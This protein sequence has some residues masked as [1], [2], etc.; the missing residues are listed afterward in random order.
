MVTEISPSTTD[1]QARANPLGY[2]FST[3]AQAAP[4]TDLA[5]GDLDGTTDRSDPAPRTAARFPHPPER[6][7][8]AQQRARRDADRLFCDVK[9]DRVLSHAR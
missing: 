4:P 9:G 1:W 6:A 3:Q 2:I 8:L 5:H 7:S